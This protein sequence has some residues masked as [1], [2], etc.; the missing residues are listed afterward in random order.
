MICG[1]G[2]RKGRVGRRRKEGE[3]RGDEEQAHHLDLPPQQLRAAG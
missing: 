1:E 2:R 3:E